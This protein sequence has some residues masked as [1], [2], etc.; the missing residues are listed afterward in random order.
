M[1]TCEFGVWLV[2]EQPATA[3]E[4]LR[5]VQ[6]ICQ[7][8]ADGNA[9]PICLA[10][11]DR[12]TV[13]STVLAIGEDPGTSRY[14]YA[15]GPPNA[16]PYEDFTPLFIELL[17]G[18]TSRQPSTNR[19]A[20]VEKR[21]EPYPHVDIEPP[22]D[23]PARRAVRQSVTYEIKPRGASA[24]A[25]ASGRGTLPS[26]DATAPY[27]I[28]L[29]GP[30]KCEALARSER[31]ASGVLVWADDGLPAPATVRLPAAW[32]DLFGS[33]RGRMRFRRRFHPPS[34]IAAADRLFHRFT[35][36]FGGSGSVSVN[37]QFLGRLESSTLSGKF[38]VTSLLGVN[39]ETKP[40]IWNLRTT[41]KMLGPAALS[42][43]SLLRFTAQHEMT[44]NSH[45]QPAGGAT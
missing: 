35:D 24:P 2:A 6:S 21:P 25:D 12:G 19:D 30:W 14:W 41:P 39:N 28:L 31:D 42:R 18:A 44:P 9:P 29:R 5:Q 37:G 3:E 22:Y 20:S 40:S 34:N 26:G 27:R 13:S 4:W 45:A 33:F 8:T 32:Q 36:F 15:A 7:L 23:S 43:P 1:T 38:D 16:T 17:K 10:G 11:S